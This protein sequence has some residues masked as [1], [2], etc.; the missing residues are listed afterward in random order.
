MT[1]KKIIL[2]LILLGLIA[3][4]FVSA[5]QINFN[6]PLQSQMFRKV[7][8]S[9]ANIFFY[10]AI[11]LGV[12]LVVAS[13]IIFITSGGNPGQTSFAKKMLIF[14]VI[15]LA[16]GFLVKAIVFLLA[17]ILNIKIAPAS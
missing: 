3:P 5:E 8:D 7:F 17:N 4:F 10:I 13:A 15:I 16:A 2:S 14:A 9:F 11:A 6:N 1:E 12:L